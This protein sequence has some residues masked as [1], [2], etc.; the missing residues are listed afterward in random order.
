MVNTNLLFK[1]TVLK[2]LLLSIKI[3]SIYWW[4]QEDVF[5]IHTNLIYTDSSKEDFIMVHTD[6]L[7]IPMVP[8]MILL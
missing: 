3:Y 5:V 6:L 7:S 2:I 1:L 8:K 4:L